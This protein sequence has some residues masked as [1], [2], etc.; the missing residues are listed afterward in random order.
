[1]ANNGR[2]AQNCGNAWY[3]RRLRSGLKPNEVLPQ[4]SKLIVH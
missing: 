2:W 3:G 1:M 4:T